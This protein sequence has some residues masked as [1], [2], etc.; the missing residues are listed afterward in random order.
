[1][2][3]PVRELAPVLAETLKVTVP[4][5][6]PVAPETIVIHGVDVAAVHAQPLVAVTVTASVPPAWPTETEDGL[7][8]KAQG[9]AACLT[10]NV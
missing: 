9:W 6:L 1:M 5:P 7:M 3:V 8:L 2:I 10:V 4:P